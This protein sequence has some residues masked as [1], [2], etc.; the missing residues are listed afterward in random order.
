[1]LQAYLPSS[2]VMSVAYCDDF[3]SLVGLPCAVGR[4]RKLPRILSAFQQHVILPYQYLK[5][6]PG[7]ETF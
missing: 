5:C 3:L 7:A 1:M 6:R 2:R 4:Y